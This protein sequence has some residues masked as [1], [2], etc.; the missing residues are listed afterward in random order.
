MID[1][2][3]LVVDDMATMRDALAT[4]LKNIGFKKVEKAI[5]GKDAMAKIERAVLEDQPYGLI[6]CD[7]IMPKMG[8]LD[9]LK[10]LQGSELHK[11]IPVI[12]V[13]TENEYSIVIEAISSGANDYIIKPYTR[14]TVLEKL[15]KVIKKK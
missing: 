7:I 10:E 12:M 1:L 13:S 15:N 11:D 3:T 8:G 5:D 4:I 14:E 9:L 6:F 2:R